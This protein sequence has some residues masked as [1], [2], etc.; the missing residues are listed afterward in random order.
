MTARQK[1]RFG[2]I[3]A[4]RIGKIH[5]ENIATRIP[6]AEVVTIADVDLPSAKWQSGRVRY[7]A[8]IR[9]SPVEFASSSNCLLMR[10][11][12]T[13]STTASTG[14]A[15]G[16][17]EASKRGPSEPRR[18]RRARGG[19]RRSGGDLGT[20]SVR[21]G[22]RGRLERACKRSGRVQLAWRWRKALDQRTRIARQLRGRLATVRPGRSARRIAGEALDRFDARLLVARRHAQKCV[23]R[24][25]SR[26][27]GHAIWHQ[28]RI[29]RP[30][31]SGA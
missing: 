15:R 21:T 24:G 3:G 11:P 8:T 26:I 16:S 2:V 18:A 23:A 25:H 13:C 6:G 31:Q 28:G 14:T 17:I 20:A 5:A 30:Q 12:M 9:R 4:G 29:H 27:P 1:I 7:G 22:F 19:A 10:T